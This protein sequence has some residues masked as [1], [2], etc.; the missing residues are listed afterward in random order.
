LHH[1][2]SYTFD[3]HLCKARTLADIVF[4]MACFGAWYLLRK[5]LRDAMHVA[6]TMGLHRAYKIHVHKDENLPKAG[7]PAYAHSKVVCWNDLPR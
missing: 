4:G 5:V 7:P 6:F 1:C 2:P 3:R